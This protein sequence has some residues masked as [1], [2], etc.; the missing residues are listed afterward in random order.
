MITKPVSIIK[1]IIFKSWLVLNR[2]ESRIFTHLTLQEKFTLFNLS[3]KCLGKTYVEIGSYLGASSCIIAAGLKKKDEAQLFCIDTWQND[4]MSEGTIDTFNLFKSNI[5]K[6]RDIL[7]P[8]RGKSAEVAKTFGDTI[9]FLFIDGDHSYEG[10]RVDV[11]TWFPKLNSGA[12]VLFHDVGWAEG[13]QQVIGE[14]VKPRAK[15][16]GRLPNLYWAWL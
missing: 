3:S 10:V 7:T 13:V 8:L 9:D 4:A 11:A 14:T 5:E 12:L 15:S 1:L 16:E 2:V 6:Y